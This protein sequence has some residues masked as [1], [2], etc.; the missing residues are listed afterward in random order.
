MCAPVI[1][2][3]TLKG[4]VTP[5]IHLTDSSSCIGPNTPLS[6]PKYQCYK[7]SVRSFVVHLKFHVCCVMQVSAPENS[8]DRPG[9]TVSKAPPTHPNDPSSPVVPLPELKPLST[10]IVMRGHSQI[11]DF[12]SDSENLP[13]KRRGTAANTSFVALTLREILGTPVAKRVEKERAPLSEEMFGVESAS[14]AVENPQ[15]LSVLGDITNEF[16][17]LNKDVCISGVEKDNVLLKENVPN[18]EN[19][20]GA[21]GSPRQASDTKHSRREDDG[22]KRLVLGDMTNPFGSQSEGLST[23]VASK[24]GVKEHVPESENMFQNE[25]G[26]ENEVKHHV[27][28]DVAHC[29]QQ[30]RGEKLFGTP[31]ARRT[32]KS[33]VQ[34]KH[35][36]S[37]GD[38]FAAA[39]PEQKEGNENTHP[40]D[41]LN[42]EKDTSGLLAELW[43][44]RHESP[45]RN[46]VPGTPPPTPSGRKQA[47]VLT[48]ELSR[49][50]PF[51]DKY[52]SF[53]ESPEFSTREITSSPQILP[54]EIHVS[55]NEQLYDTTTTD[56]IGTG[57]TDFLSLSVP[58]AIQR[59]DES[60]EANGDIDDGPQSDASETKTESQDQRSDT[61]NRQHD[62][63]CPP[64]DPDLARSD[65]D[66]A[67]SDTDHPQRDT[68]LSRSDTDHPQS[69][70][71]H[72][73]RDTDH[74]QRDTDRARSDTDHPRGRRP[75]P[76]RRSRES[77]WEVFNRRNGLARRFTMPAVPDRRQ[78]VARGGHDH[79]GGR[80][81]PRRATMPTVRARGHFVAQLGMLVALAVWLTAILL[82]LRWLMR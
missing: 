60:S 47:G 76:T 24:L 18:V 20:F 40:G 26:Y 27:L 66:L 29:D 78:G 45:S 14:V 4:L 11:I 42:S 15:K 75:P 80:G 43:K 51:F 70:T 16:G 8:E 71:D 1:L 50:S 25:Q 17:R 53:E 64:R 3:I 48:S 62:T 68:D 49:N 41:D 69:D 39:S 55:Q 22:F 61:E 21:K 58:G 7:A 34:D 9:V 46:E 54:E 77:L 59:S 30:M 44:S 36:L 10:P 32:R 67:G 73:Q 23:C 81:R 65:I 31:A 72:P 6:F 12:E 28:G 79:A 56:A 5:L 38:I 63:D 35:D 37:F 52:S 82:W 13:P 74:Q 2:E 33:R 57:S 19:V